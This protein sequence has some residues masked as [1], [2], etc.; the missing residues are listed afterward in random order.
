MSNFDVCVKRASLTSTGTTKVSLGVRKRG[1][2]NS[3]STGSSA[4]AFASSRE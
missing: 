2:G 3:L 1:T 4:Y